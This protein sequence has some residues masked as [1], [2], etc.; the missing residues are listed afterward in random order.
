MGSPC[1]GE[2]AC[3]E[4]SSFFK[5]CLPLLLLPQAAEM[6]F[7]QQL[8]PKYLHPPPAVPPQNAIM[9]HCENSGDSF[10]CLSLFMG[11]CCPSAPNVTV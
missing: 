2:A 4:G 10:Q 6:K 8:L 1:D 3:F 7:L 9:E 11:E 5:K